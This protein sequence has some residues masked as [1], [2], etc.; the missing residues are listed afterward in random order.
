VLL[1]SQY[2]SNAFSNKRWCCNDMPHL[3]LSQ[4]AFQKIADV[5]QGVAGIKYR[6]V[7]CPK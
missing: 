4:Y 6:P 2:P 5:N 3:D 1:Q 7:A